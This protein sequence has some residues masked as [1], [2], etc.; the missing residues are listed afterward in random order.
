MN[1]EFNMVPMLICC[2]VGVLNLF[3]DEYIAIGMV[4]CAFERFAG[5]STVASRKKVLFLLTLARKN[6]TRRLAE[7]KVSI[8]TAVAPWLR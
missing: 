2:G 3:A 1:V 5:N 6:D 4:A 8:R 7:K